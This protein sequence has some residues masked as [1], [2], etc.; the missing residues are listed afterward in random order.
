[1]IEK[2]KTEKKSKCPKWDKK[3][4]LKYFLERLKL[5]NKSVNHNTKFLDMMDAPQEA[6]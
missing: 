3:E 1:M 2:I 6:G 5:W 4:N